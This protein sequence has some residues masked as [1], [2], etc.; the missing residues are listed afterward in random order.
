MQWCDLV[1][2]QSPPPGFKQ[3]LGDCHDWL[4]FAFLVEMGLPHVG[5][6]DLELLASSDLP[7]LASQSVG[8][9]GMSHCTQLE[10]ILKKKD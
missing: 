1:S 5:Q 3:L 10:L 4:I 8:I 7:A 2:L 6:D 9:P